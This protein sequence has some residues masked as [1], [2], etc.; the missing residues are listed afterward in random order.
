MKVLTYKEK[1]LG[2]S[3]QQGTVQQA[4]ALESGSLVMCGIE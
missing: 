1:L 4:Q 2:S 3:E